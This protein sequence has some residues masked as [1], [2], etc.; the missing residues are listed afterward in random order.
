MIDTLIALERACCTRVVATGISVADGH[1]YTAE[2]THANQYRA[3]ADAHDQLVA[4]FGGVERFDLLH[5]VVIE[6]SP[7]T[8]EMLPWWLRLMCGGKAAW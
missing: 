8:A 4:H 1:R 3:W 6:D 2:A 5:P 7:P